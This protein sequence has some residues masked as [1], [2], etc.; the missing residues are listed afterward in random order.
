[1]RCL[2]RNPACHICRFADAGNKRHG[3]IQGISND[4]DSCS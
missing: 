2:P 1:M 4:P 3:R